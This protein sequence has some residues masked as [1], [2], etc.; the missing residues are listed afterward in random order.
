L[1][2]FDKC[3]DNLIGHVVEIVKP[4]TKQGSLHVFAL[5]PIRDFENV[6]EVIGLVRLDDIN[7]RLDS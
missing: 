2:Y 7:N 1:L 5:K 4:K 6:E 3:N